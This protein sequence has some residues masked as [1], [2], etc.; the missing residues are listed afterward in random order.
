MSA[1]QATRHA[2]HPRPHPRRRPG[3]FALPRVERR[4]IIT[5]ALLVP[6][7]HVAVRVI[8]YRRTLAVAEWTAT[9][10]RWRRKVDTSDAAGAVV[11]AYRLA[12]ARV[13]RYS[14][15][16]GNCLSRSLALWWVLRRRGAAPEL[17]LGVSLGGGDFAAHAWVELG[18][19]AVNDRQDVALRFT[20]LTGSTPAPRW[21]D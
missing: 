19:L 11:E 7:M 20:P 13:Q 3:W 14:L 15:L 6:A 8:D 21:M 4:A 12:T 16:P 2:P 9:R 10:A 18:G 5:L 1:D 17:R